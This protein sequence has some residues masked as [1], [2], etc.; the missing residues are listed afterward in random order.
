MKKNRLENIV[1]IAIALVLVQTFLEDAAVLADWPWKVRRVLLITGFLFDLF[2]TVEFLVRLYYA[3]INSRGSEY[4]FHER[5]WID[6]LASVPLAVFSSGPAFLGLL[7]GGIPLG[8]LGRTLNV[9]K[10]VKAVRIARILR[11]LR[12]L[13]IFRQIKHTDSVMAQR[14]IAKISGITIGAVI[15]SLMGFSLLQGVLRTETLDSAIQDRYLSASSLMAAAE[16]GDF[17]RVLSDV[18]KLEPGLL[19]VRQQGK[20]LYSRFD[21]SYYEG[22]LGPF[23]YGYQKEGNLEFFYD[24]RPLNKS[25]SRDGLTYFIIIIVLLL[26]YLLYYSPHF[27]ITVTDPLYVM[28]RGFAE[29]GYNLKAKI[30]DRFRSDDVYLLAEKYNEEY[31]PLKD[32]DSHGGESPGLDLKMEDF[33]DLLKKG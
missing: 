18:T 12:F 21:A 15:F 28:Y 9:L 29:K 1:M 32:R 8:G 23:D 20:T 13:K 7:A 27:A 33:S 14:H 30:P 26:V 6:F 10:V 24:L 4:F 31:L 17:S 5:G 19:L 16:T 22:R 3:S 2:F 11:M 25:Q